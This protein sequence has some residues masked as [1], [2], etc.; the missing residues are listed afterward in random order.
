MAFSTSSSASKIPARRGAKAVHK[1]GGGSGHEYV[2]RLFTV[3]EVHLG[4]NY[5]RSFVKRIKTVHKVDRGWS[6]RLAM[7]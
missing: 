7:G 6:T 5:P 4:N 2:P 3:L 1:V